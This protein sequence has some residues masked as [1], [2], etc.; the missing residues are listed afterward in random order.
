[1]E[2][3]KFMPEKR[4]SF[5]DIKASDLIRENCAAAGC[6]NVK[7]DGDNYSCKL[8]KPSKVIPKLEGFGCDDALTSD[9]M[10]NISVRWGF[11]AKQPFSGK[12]RYF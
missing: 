5:L 10:G 4:Q 6:R 3:G 11:V 9:Q 2:Q 7:K 12:T 8:Y 1:M